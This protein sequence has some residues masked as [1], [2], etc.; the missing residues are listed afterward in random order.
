M[1]KRNPW[2]GM[3]SYNSS[4]KFCGRN[5]CSTEFLNMIENYSFVTRLENSFADKFSNEYAIA[6]VNGTVT[7]HAALE[8]AGV[9]EGDEVIV[10]A[11]TMSSTNMCV[12]FANAIPAFVKC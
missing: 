11:L 9:G 2:P 10:P 5:N 8:V 4:Y 12:L 1:N 6:M 7:L 3:A